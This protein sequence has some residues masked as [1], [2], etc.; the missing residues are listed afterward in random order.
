MCTFT[1]YKPKKDIVIGFNEPLLAHNQQSH[2]LGS[3][4]ISNL[5]KNNNANFA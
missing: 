3:S 1:L 5:E 2:F 4:N